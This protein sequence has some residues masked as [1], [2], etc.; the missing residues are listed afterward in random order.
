VNDFAGVLPAP[1]RAELDALLRRTAEATSA[2]IAVATVPSLAGMTVEEYAA[3]LFEQ[4]GI[5]KKAT[6][7]GVLILVA[8]NDRA[9]RIEVGYGLEPVLPDGLAGEIVRSEFLP[10]FREGDYPRGIRRGVG[11]IVELVQKGEIAPAEPGLADSEFPLWFIVPFLGVFVSLGAFAVGIGVR[12]KTVG[13]VLWGGMF[14]GGPL[15]MSLAFGP[16]T[17]MLGSL[18]FGMLIWGYRKGQT[19]FWTK[20]LRGSATGADSFGWTMGTSGSSGSSGGG[21][22]SGSDFGGGSSGGGGA[23]GR[24]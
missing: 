8:P 23:S 18:A 16:A 17:L 11:R 21:S 3:G 20:T 7:N 15:V 19:P 4:W 22:P 10:A 24:W 1:V 2:E 5:G 14:A 9:M 12:S 6:D 13:P